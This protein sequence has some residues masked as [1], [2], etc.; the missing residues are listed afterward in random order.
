MKVGAVIF[1]LDGPILDSFREGLRRIKIVCAIYDI[2]FNREH[3]KKLTELWGLPGIELLTQGLGLNEEFAKTTFYP[4]WERLDLTQ[5]VPLV[6]R[7]REVL[8]W[9]VRNKIQAT[10]L[11]SRHREHLL[12]MFERIDLTRYF[13]VISTKFDTPYRKPDPRVFWYT[14]EELR[15]KF[16]IEK[17]E[18]LFVGDTPADVDAGQAVE[19]ETLLV[20]TGPYLLKHAQKLPLQLSNILNSID[21]LPG[22]I[23]EHQDNSSLL[24]YD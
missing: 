23:E 15:D 9:L 7:T 19:I 13:S 12:D 8:A 17:R 24:P 11:T 14:F 5:P 20:Q 3:Y 1:D 22:W 6:T 10:I 21:D 18:C 2:P 16:G 4:A